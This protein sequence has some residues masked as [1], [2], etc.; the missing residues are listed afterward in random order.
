MAV[1]IPEH[2]LTFI[3]IPKTGGTSITRW[4]R[5][6]HEHDYYR[7]HC[8]LQTAKNHW[9]NLSQTFCVIRDPYDW[10]VSW[11]EYE[12]VFIKNRIEDI[13]LGK[14]KSFKTYLLCP[15]YKTSSSFSA[16]V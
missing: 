10:L 4:I 3:H 8:T 9:N 5:D 6:N 14:I 11:Y 16:I 12:K 2:N 7:K 15:E 13:K 1:H